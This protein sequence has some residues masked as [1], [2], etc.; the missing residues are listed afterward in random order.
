MGRRCAQDAGGSMKT[1]AEIKEATALIIVAFMKRINKWAFKNRYIPKEHRALI[2]AA[3][4]LSVLLWC[5]D[6]S[7]AQESLPDF[8]ELIV[9]LRADASTKAAVN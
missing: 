6:D 5:L 2:S 1:E 4:M 3:H 8:G 7:E 9:I